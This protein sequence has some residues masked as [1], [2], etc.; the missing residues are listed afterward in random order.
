MSQL[1]AMKS[2]TYANENIFISHARTVALTPHY[3]YLC[4]V[5]A[6]TVGSTI[7][8]R[9]IHSEDAKSASEK[10]WLHTTL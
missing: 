2:L 6:Q 1:L 4:E 5:V 3:A 7:L 8:F 10:C 9:C